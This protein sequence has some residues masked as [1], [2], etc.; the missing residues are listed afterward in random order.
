[1]VMIAPSSEVERAAGPRAADANKHRR[2]DDRRDVPPPGRETSSRSA[3]ARRRAA[4]FA[5]PRRR[6]AESVGA[7][8]SPNRERGPSSADCVEKSELRARSVLA[9]DSAPPRRSGSAMRV[10]TRQCT[11]RSG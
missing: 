2:A 1:M 11:L 8:R 3:H 10:V 9:L 6:D 7:M 5:A 4:P